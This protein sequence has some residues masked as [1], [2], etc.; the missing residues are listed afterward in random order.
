M[1]ETAEASREHAHELR[2]SEPQ[3]RYLTRGLPEPGGKLKLIFIGGLVPRKAC[4]IGLRAAAPLLR[5]DL[6]HFTI[7]GDGPERQRLE[8]LVRSLQ[9]EKGVSFCGWLGHAAPFEFKGK[10]LRPSMVKVAV[11]S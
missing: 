1:A 5:K 6:A 9:I 7:I 4:Y 8:E 3:L 2:P 10:L 11:H